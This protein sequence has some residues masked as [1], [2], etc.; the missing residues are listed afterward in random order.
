MKLLDKFNF[1][2]YKG[3]TLKCVLQN[4]GTYVVWCLKNISNTVDE[5]E[6]N[7]KNN[8]VINFFC[9]KNALIQKACVTFPRNLNRWGLNSHIQLE[10]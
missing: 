6:T 2:K 8:L 1:G 3:Q 10:V 7:W 5:I 9:F 4:H